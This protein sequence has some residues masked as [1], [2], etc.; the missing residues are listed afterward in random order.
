MGSEPQD[1]RDDMTLSEM[2]ENDAYMVEERIKGASSYFFISMSQALKFVHAC[3]KKT[4]D[5][6]GV[7]VRPDSEPR[8]VDRMLKNRK[9]QV[10]HRNKYKGVDGW[11]NGIYIY[12]DGE[13]IAFIST[14]LKRHKEGKVDMLIPREHMEFIVIT[15]AKKSTKMYFDMKQ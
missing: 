6:L 2:A 4:L 5:R 10:E 12:K 11:R 7:K 14:V 1:Y 9:V 3:M 13:L 15:N 8:F